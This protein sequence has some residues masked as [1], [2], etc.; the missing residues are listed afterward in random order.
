MLFLF[1][2]LHQGIK[3]NHF[4]HPEQREKRDEADEAHQYEKNGHLIG[5]TEFVCRVEVQE[6]VKGTEADRDADHRFK[7]YAREE[8]KALV[9]RLKGTQILTTAEKPSA[10]ERNKSDEHKVK[11]SNP[12]EQHNGA[13]ALDEI[14]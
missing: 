14:D 4:R 8:T 1:L 5:Y 11:G 6:V 13:H 7:E 10:Q 12:Q 3:R 9:P 2:P